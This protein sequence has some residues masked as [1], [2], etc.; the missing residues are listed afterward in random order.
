MYLF[1][2]IIPH[3]N[4]PNLLK[5]CLDS[6]PKRNDIQIIIV[7]DN[8]NLTQEEFIHF[9]GTNVPNIEIYFTKEEKG[10]GYARN[11]GLNHAKGEW[12]LFADADDIFLPEIEK[13]LLL[14][15]RES[16]DIIYFGVIQKIQD[17]KTNESIYKEYVDLSQP[18]D[19]LIYNIN[20]VW[21]KV[22]KKSFIVKHHITFDEVM[23]G[24]DIK[25]SCLCDFY[26]S[27]IV[28]I[29]KNAYCYIIRENSLYTTKNIEWCICR[30]NVIMDLYYFMKNHNQN[31]LV[32]Q[33]KETAYYLLSFISQYSHKTHIKYL[34][35]YGIRIKSF[36]ILLISLPITILYYIKQRL[37]N[38]I[39]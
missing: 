12:I 5:R 39:R 31:K 28:I 38:F 25:F 10:A 21:G 8:S 20:P 23:Y 15:E 16:A 18:I 36:K 26:A 17:I 27:N 32:Q 24:N 35:T 37:I 34:F 13:V 7:D 19:K 30:Y 33:Y 2:I 3:K 14:T 11:I 29:N 6:I 1:T 4:I 9:P 22:F